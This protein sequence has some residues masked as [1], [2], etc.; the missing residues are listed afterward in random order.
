M[1]SM[2][3]KR[4]LI[5]RA[6][7]IAFATAL[8]CNSRTGAT[9]KDAKDPAKDAELRA[10][11]DAAYK[12]KRYEDCALL[13]GRLTSADGGQG[14][15]EDRF[16]DRYNAA[17]C[18]ALAGQRDRALAELD[19]LVNAGER[20]VEHLQRDGDLVGLHDDPRWRALIG[21]AQANHDRYLALVNPHLRRLYEQDQADRRGGRGKINWAEVIGADADRRAEAQLILASGGAR[22]ADDYYHAAMVFQHGATVEDYRK[23]H[24]L[25]LKAVELEPEH[26]A[27]WLAAA[28]KDRELVHQGKPQLYGTQFHTQADGASVRYP[29]DP[30]ITNAERARWRV[31]PIQESK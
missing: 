3:A 30:S 18:L 9:V 27:L 11:A 31:P 2:Q 28:A 20:D 21:R 7:L 15:V 24:E 14:K 8:A 16:H 4:D 26:R 19:R 12:A 5:A 25:A 10:R 1:H 23:A 13:Y 29:V 22:V 17:C 6:L